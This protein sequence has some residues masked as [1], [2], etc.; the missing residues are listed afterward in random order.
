MNIAY[1]VPKLANKGPII[2]VLELVN[3]MIKNGH[4]CT[5]FFFDKERE[6]QVPCP[7]QQISFFQSIEFNKFDIIHT[8]GLRPDCYIFFHKP[9]H[10]TAKI[11]STLHN[12]VIT[13]FSYQYNKFIAY[14][15]GNLWM[16]MLKR[17]DKIITLTKNALKYYTHWF[18]PQKLTYAYNTRNIPTNQ[19]ISALETENILQF[20]GES[21]LIGVNAALTPRKGIDQLI[22]AL[23]HL[24]N[25]KLII[26]G[27]GKSM[28]EL[29]Q[30]CIDN[31]TADRVLFL[32]YKKDAYR[33]LSYYDLYALP[34]RS[35]GFVLTL[36]EAAILKKQ[37]I[38]S[39]IPVFTEIV[40]DSE[41]AFFDLDNIPSLIKAIK[42]AQ[43]E[44]VLG[45]N[46]YKKYIQTFSPEKFYDRHYS[47]YL[48]TIN[49]RYLD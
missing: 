45:E 47:I 46:L 33:F 31:S 30:Q 34:S 9:I 8:H 16:L 7:T 2:V 39:N 38:C 26:I 10:C 12:Y 22:Q 11:I 19:P 37:V 29:K 44:K 48:A 41:V 28:K 42:R 14:T 18:S 23:P 43:N 13:D 35:E 15:I 20:K 6:I 32:G 5:V 17:H 27:N 24:P 40:T 4:Q 25:Y 3:Q 49:K 1:I 36:I 21:I